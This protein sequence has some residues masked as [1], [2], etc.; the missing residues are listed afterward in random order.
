MLRSSWKKATLVFCFVFLISMVMGNT[1]LIGRAYAA[2]G[3]VTVDYGVTTTTAG[4]YVFGISCWPRMNPDYAPKLAQAGV[5]MIR[6]S[7]LLLESIVPQTTIANY[8]NNVNDVQNPSTWNWNPGVNTETMP[9]TDVAPFQNAGIKVF[10]ILSGIPSWLGYNGMNSMPRNW[11]IY[12]DLIKKLFQ[13]YHD[14]IGYF[15]IFNEPEIELNLTGSG[16]TD[17]YTAYRDIYYHSLQAINPVN[18][19]DRMLGGPANLANPAYLH[20][21]LSDPGIKDDIDFASWHRYNDTAT[22]DCGIGEWKYEAAEHGKPDLPLFVTEYNIYADIIGMDNPD[23]I[24]WVAGRITTLMKNGATGAFLY[25]TDDRASGLNAQVRH[26]WKIINQ[27]GTFTPRVWPIRLLSKQLGLGSGD[28]KM[29]QTS[30]NGV[31]IATGAVNSEG[32]PVVWVVNDTAAS[33]ATDITLNNIGLTGQVTLSHYVASNGISDASSVYNVENKNVIGSSVST[34]ITVPAK[35]VYGIVVSKNLA[36][37]KPYTTTVPASPT[38]PDTAGTELTD[39]AFGDLSYLSTPWQGRSGLS[40]FSYT[41]DLG[42]VQN[43]NQF[44][45]NFLRDDTVKIDLPSSVQYSVSSDN[46]TFTAVGTVNTPSSAEDTTNVYKFTGNAAGRYVKVTVN[47]SWSSSHWAFIDEVRVLQSAS[48]TQSPGNIAFGKPATASTELIE[49]GKAVDGV[50]YANNNGNCWASAL[51]NDVGAWWK[52]DLGSSQ[53]ISVV[54]VQY[55]GFQNPSE[56]LWFH[57]TPKT[58]TIQVSNDN[59]NWTT[60]HNRSTNVPTVHTAYS[61]D[62]Y[63]Y[64]MNTTGRYIKLIFEDGTDDSTKYAEIVEVEVYN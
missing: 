24:S 30:Y 39:G 19:Y 56:P 54:K 17:V 27:D 59:T 21:M 40:S 22:Y 20:S 38:Y 1:I 62:L 43:I 9:E 37:N 48:S 3:S 10:S 5:T 34:T 64:N 46:S 60:V 53:S 11:S 61:P 4:K 35:S 57:M 28:N 7:S 25:G 45:A 42:T 14:R 18:T 29:K 15:E 58:L 51:N 33:V 32:F 26:D 8:L 16:Y 52:V 63:S 50:Y 2:T 36:L 6:Q 41:I 49:A 13:H 23:A 44:Q 47:G 12:E 55:R 31:T